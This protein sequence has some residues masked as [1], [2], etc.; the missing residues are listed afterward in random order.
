VGSEEMKG[1]EDQGFH[2]PTKFNY[3]GEVDRLGILK[4]A[5]LRS[6]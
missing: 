4:G 6:S 1:G 2:R 3:L 5:Y